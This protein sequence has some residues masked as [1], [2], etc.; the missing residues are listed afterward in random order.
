MSRQKHLFY[1]RKL[2]NCCD[3]EY[4]SLRQCGSGSQSV[5]IIPW[6]LSFSLNFIFYVCL[7]LVWV[8]SLLVFYVTSLC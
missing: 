5:Y 2:L 4:S 6:L 7:M 1:G 8:V 3:D